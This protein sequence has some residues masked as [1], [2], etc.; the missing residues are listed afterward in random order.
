MKKLAVTSVVVF[1]VLIGFIGLLCFLPDN[2]C[3]EKKEGCEMREEK[4]GGEMHGGKPEG[5]GKGQGH[6]EGCGQE[7]CMVKEWKDADGK[8]HKEVK[9]II[10]GKGNDMNRGNGCPMESMDHSGCCGCCMMKQG[11]GSCKMMK[12]DSI[13]TDSV[14]VKV[15]GKL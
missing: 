15:R 6:H 9:V 2:E 8:V 10:D 5:C 14:R 12:I 3:C 1:V 4:C 13:E 11:G 7:K